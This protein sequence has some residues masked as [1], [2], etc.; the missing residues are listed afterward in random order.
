[1]PVSIE[2]LESSFDQ[3]RG[4][5]GRLDHEIRSAQKRAQKRR[6]RLTRS[7]QDRAEAGFREARDR[8]DSLRD[9]VVTEFEAALKKNPV[10][11]RVQ[12]LRRNAGARF[13]G[14]VERAIAALPV[15]SR[16]EVEKMNRKIN[17]LQ[18]KVRELEKT[19]SASA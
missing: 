1:M 2:N 6:D 18:R 7:V 11:G 17:R 10:V 5:A 15:A 3:I 14:S 16:R 12:D 19:R 13:A 4:A 8:A 9:R